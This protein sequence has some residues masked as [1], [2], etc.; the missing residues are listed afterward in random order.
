MSQYPV[1]YDPQ[2]AFWSYY[3]PAPEALLAPAKWAGWVMIVLGTL[4]L[5]LGT[6]NGVTSYVVSDET[7]LKQIQEMPKQ[8][9][10]F[11]ITPDLM[12]T[13]NLVM[14]IVIAVY[15]LVLI[16]LGVFVRRGT[17][18]PIILSMLVIAL[19]LL[20]VTG[21]VLFSAVAGAAALIGMALIACFPAILMIAALVLLIRAAANTSKIAQSV[22][23]MEA[24]RI[25]QMQQ[26]YGQTPPQ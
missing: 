10:P 18:L 4:L 15:A 23:Q 17:L 25:A 22:A 7:L 9:T 8:E 20:L 21:M 1:G 2:Y 19:P 13:L 11:T 14:A 16:V 24:M 5:L 6:C 3:S 12:R 26:Y